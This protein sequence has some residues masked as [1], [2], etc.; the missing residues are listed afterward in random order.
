MDS[1]VLIIGLGLRVL[2]TVVCINK[3]K[4]LNR[5]PT[6]WGIF[7]FFMPLVAIIWIQFMKPIIVLDKNLGMKKKTE[8]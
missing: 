8:V 3:A 1:I 7:G 6:V 5:D 4:Q 2:G